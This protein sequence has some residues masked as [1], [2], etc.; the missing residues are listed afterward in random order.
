M[1]V[2][3]QKDCK[4]HIY[5]CPAKTAGGCGGGVG[6]RGDLVDLFISE[7]VL[8]KL[9]EAR[10]AAPADAG[11]WPKQAEFD[12]VKEQLAELE[13]KWKNREIGNDM[14]FRLAPGLE[15][16]IRRLRGDKSKFEASFHRQQAHATTNMEEIRRRWFL[17]EDEGGLPLSTKR[18]YVREALHAVIVYPAGKGR[19]KFN[20]DLLDPI[21]R[22]S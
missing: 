22:E 3:R 21:W 8:A 15:E 18:T 4:Q 20:P 13:R 6:R 11:T 12:E 16:E 10:F 2:T 5:I 17:P 1:R 9:E 19:R 14:F 7:A